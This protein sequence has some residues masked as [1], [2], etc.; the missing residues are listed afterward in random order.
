MRK[1]LFPSLMLILSTAAI[2]SACGGEVTITQ[3]ITTTQRQTLS[4]KLTVTQTKTQTRTITL[5]PTQNQAPTETT[6]TE[7]KLPQEILYSDSFDQIPSNWSVFSNNDG[8]A[9]VKNGAIFI[10]NYTDS[11]GASDSYPGE[12]FSDFTI[13][14]EM[15][16]AGGADINWQSV[17]CRYSGFTYYTFN[18]SADGY[19]AIYLVDF[20]GIHT[21]TEPTYSDFIHKGYSK[22]MVSI[23]CIG[24]NLSLTVNGQKLTHITDST[25][26]SGEIGLAVYSMDGLYSEAS[27]DNLVVYG[28]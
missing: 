4:E 28:P 12:S 23:E 2:I 22:N 15:T 10:K 9:A 13:E 26:S 19:Y 24:S 18:I 27:F 14:V 6:V 5:D 21:L 20:T 25:R 8:Y 1:L 7:A 11:D 17:I 16:F 3:T